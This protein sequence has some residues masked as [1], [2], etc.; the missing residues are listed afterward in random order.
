M[1]LQEIRAKYIAYMQSKGHKVI[2]SASLL[3][4]NDPTTLFTGSGMQPLLPYLLGKEHPLGTRVV[5]SQKCFRQ[6]DI[7]EVG[8]NRHTTFF[9]MLGNW[10]FGDYFKEEQL[11]WVFEFLTSPTVGLGIDPS[12]LYVTVFAGDDANAIERD[13]KAVAI[14]K[15]LY[16]TVGID[17]SDVF[18]GKE[19]DGA[20]KGMQGGRIFYYDAKKNWWSR[21]GVPENMPKGEPGGP[22][23]ELFYDFGT[24]HN[25]AF[26]EHCHPNCDCGRFLEIGNSVF[27]EY[28]KQE[29]GSFAKLPKSNV[30]FGGGLERLCAAANHVNDVFPIAHKEILETL[31]KASGKSY[32]HATASELKAFRVVADHLKGAVFIIAD[33]ARPANTDSGYVLRRLLRRAV[34]YADSLSIKEGVLKDAASVV[35]SMYKDHYPEL[36]ALES[37]ITTVIAE[38]EDRFRK[39][40]ERG[41]KEFEKISAT[42]NISGVDA[43]VLFTTYGFPIEMTEEMAQERGVSVDKAT[44]AEEM[45]KHQEL[46]RAGAEQ[47]FK[48]GLADHS[49]I[50]VKYH[51]ATHL[52]NQAL[53]EVLGAHIEQR[54]SNITSERLRFDFNHP[55][56]ISEE[57]LRAV[58]KIVND[59]I[60]EDLIVTA[61][62]M[63]LAQAKERGAVGVFGEKY[64]EVVR[65]YSI[66]D[67]MKPFSMEL[68][69]GPHVDH[70]GVLGTFHITKEES[71]A[72]GTRRIKAVLS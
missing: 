59:K 1:T 32:H 48:G 42:G 41:L 52:L 28:I 65:V 50:V 43:F 19:S 33:G 23:S 17:A 37:T 12:N 56:K 39:T 46:S 36:V 14:W 51:T 54:G 40:L 22:D 35:I 68:C 2:P 57:Q 62:D 11:N 47:K 18:I 64:G 61:T 29:D 60:K 58:E 55:E 24:P 6:M 31:E 34:R 15:Q 21:A 69:G 25:T 3:P 10:S 7:E 38:E 20:S 70:T 9:E 66:G 49:E 4:Q 5:D 26:G 72:A 45:R 16:A 8:D 30:D 67:P 27:M 71:V 13:D 53:K 44:Y 63:P